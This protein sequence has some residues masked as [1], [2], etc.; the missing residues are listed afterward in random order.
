MRQSVGIKTVR[1]GEVNVDVT[2]S[3]ERKIMPI[4]LANSEAGVGIAAAAAALQNGRSALDA[5]ELG[6]RLVELDPHIRS[7]GVGGW[8]NLLGQVELDAS[9]MD[10]R[11]LR[12]GAVGALCGFLHP[13][14]LIH[15]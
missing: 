2:L 7:V 14:S 9:I 10:G 3:C 15:I 13:L 6:I 5:V 8:P 12:A 4:I 11:T 1:N